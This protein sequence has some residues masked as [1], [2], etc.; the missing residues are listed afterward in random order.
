MFKVERDGYNMRNPARCS[1]ILVN[2]LCGISVVHVFRRQL[3][4]PRVYIARGSCVFCFVYVF[5]FIYLSVL[6]SYSV[7]ERV[8]TLSSGLK[9]KEKRKY[10]NIERER[11]KERERKGV[12][13]YIEY[14]LLVFIRC[15]LV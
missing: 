11:E 10:K 9:R 6:F 1:T 7:A 2:A 3:E 13:V 14:C 4:A 8:T 15:V 5:A 12:C